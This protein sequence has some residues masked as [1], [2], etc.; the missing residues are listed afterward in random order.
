E[1]LVLVFLLELDEARDFLAAGRAPGG[2]EVDDQHLAV[3][4]RGGGLLAVRQRHGPIGAFAVVP[5][6]GLWRARDARQHEGGQNR[7]HHRSFSLSIGI[8][9]FDTTPGHPCSSILSGSRAP[10]RDASPRRRPSSS[11]SSR[12]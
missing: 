10:G 4:V 7:F 9:T 1:A 11:A 3:V 2:P 5:L 8:I 12:R 6:L